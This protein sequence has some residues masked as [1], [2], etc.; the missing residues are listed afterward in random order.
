MR[1]DQAAPVDDE[2]GGAQKPA[3]RRSHRLRQAEPRALQLMLE[4]GLL[5]AQRVLFDGEGQQAAGQ[6]VVPRPQRRELFLRE[7]AAS[8]RLGRELR[9]EGSHLGLRGVHRLLERLLV[10][11]EKGALP[12]TSLRPERNSWAVMA[13][14]PSG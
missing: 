12:A 5:G 6:P 13:R 3:Q 7:R 9:L 4:V 1:R 2:G 11:H 14:L 8:L 10:R